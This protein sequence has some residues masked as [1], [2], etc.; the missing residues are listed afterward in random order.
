[1]KIHNTKGIFLLFIFIYFCLAKDADC[2]AKIDDTILYG[3]CRGILKHGKFMGYYSSGI[4]KWEVHY[5]YDILHGKFIHFY[6]NGEIHFIGS[7]KNG[8]LNGSFTQYNQQNTSLVANFKKGVLHN[9]LYIFRD[10]EKI[11]GF[12]YYY[13][14]ITQRRYFE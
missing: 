12:K 9:W 10:K 3:K 11:Q 4:P 14:K 8:V 2:Y 1:M 5:K 13:G 6:S 7:Y